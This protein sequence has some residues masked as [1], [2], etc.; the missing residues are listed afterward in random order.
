MV[1]TKKT[2]KEVTLMSIIP[3]FEVLVNCLIEAEETFLNNPKD[4]YTLE[5]AVKTSTEAFAAGFLGEVLSSVNV[6][7]FFYHMTF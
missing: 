2:L 7:E 5:R 1:S 3:L 4:F 6:N